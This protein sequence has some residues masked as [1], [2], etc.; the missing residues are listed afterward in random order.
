MQFLPYALPLPTVRV[1]S[2]GS[3]QRR[4]DGH[5]VVEG[6]RFN[7]RQHGDGEGGWVV[8]GG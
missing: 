8:S 7:K 6:G 5:G 3:L 1:F 4:L 2:P